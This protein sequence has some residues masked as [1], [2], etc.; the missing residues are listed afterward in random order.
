MI[1]NNSITIMSQRIIFLKII[2]FYI[3]DSPLISSL[4]RLMRKATQNITIENSNFLDRTQIPGRPK[5]ITKQFKVF[6]MFKQILMVEKYDGL[7]LHSLNVILHKYQHYSELHYNIL[8]ILFQVINSLE[9]KYLVSLVFMSR[10]MLQISL[11]QSTS[12]I[13]SAYT[14]GRSRHSRRCSTAFI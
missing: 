11:D 7:F 4:C 1:Y 8:I 14:E 12:R 13:T 10:Q 2:E 6:I 3:S 5:D 9:P